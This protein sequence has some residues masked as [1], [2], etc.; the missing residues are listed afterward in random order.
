MVGLGAF[1]PSDS[2]TRRAGGGLTDDGVRD[3]FMILKSE[4]PARRSR[5]PRA[6]VGVPAV[7]R[8]KNVLALQSSQF[9]PP[10]TSES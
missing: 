7:R 4:G 10:G 1:I 6:A 8:G 5:H 3:L 2:G 9:M